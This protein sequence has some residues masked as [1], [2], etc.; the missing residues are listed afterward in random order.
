MSELT[1]YGVRVF[2]DDLEAARGFYGGTLGLGMAW[3]GPEATG[4]AVGP[5]VLIVERA[6]PA[7]P[8]GALV[9]RFAGITLCVESIGRSFAELSSRGVPFEG[10]PEPQDWGGMLAHFRDPA[11][12]VL[13]LLG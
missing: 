7:G 3:E 11:G 4:Y 9:G 10:P 13:T 2:V 8:Y 5:A 6:D 1:L 12:N